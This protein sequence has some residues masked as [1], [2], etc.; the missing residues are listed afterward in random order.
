MRCS[1]ASSRRWRRRAASARILS[2]VA[3]RDRAALEQ[4]IAK[5]S[6]GQGDIDPVDAALSDS[7]ER[8]ASFFVT[9]IDDDGE[10]DSEAAI[11]YALDNTERRALESQIKQQQK[12]DTVGQLAG[13]IAHD[14]NN[15]LSAIMMATDFLL[16]A[17]KPTDPSFSDI[18][19][20]KQNANRAA[21]L[22][23]QL[24]AFSRRQTLRPQVL[25]LG[26]LLS[27]LTHSAAPADRR[28]G[29]ARRRSWPRPLAG[30]GRPVAIR[31]GHRQSRG[32]C[33]R[34]DAG[35]R[36]ADDPHRQHGVRAMPRLSSYKGHAGR[37]LRAGR[38]DRHRHRHAARG[39]GADFRAVLLDQGGRQGNGLGLSTVY[40]IV[41]QTGGFIYPESELGHGSTFRIF[42]PRHVAGQGRDQA[43]RSARARGARGRRQSGPGRTGRSHRPRHGAAGRG[44]GRLA[45]AQ[46]TRAFVARLYR[47][48]PPA[49]ASRRW[50][51]WS[52]T[53]ARWISW[54][55][56]W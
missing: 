40:G 51:N 30:Q 21:S 35:R 7:A 14:F 6:Q 31:A 37:R 13:G 11:I 56:T 9:A 39:H 25:D 1:R 53:R 20:I 26:E 47:A 54:S 8:S 41:K 36:Q 44:R 12:M 38:S 23:R 4:A 49:T 42:L 27:D 46:R 55:P 24:L 43:G 33:A 48:R 18:M 29:E 15:V 22:V 10:R 2:T 28:E 17:H 52:A 32:Q 16:S 19:Q 3:E 5:A 34:R 50:K 45:G